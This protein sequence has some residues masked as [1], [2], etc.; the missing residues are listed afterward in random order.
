MAQ[1]KQHYYEAIIAG[2]GIADVTVALMFE[3]V[4]ITYVLLED[5]DT[6]ESD[7]GAGIDCI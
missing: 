6:L 1:L 5:R 7:R 4:G 2:G 3:N